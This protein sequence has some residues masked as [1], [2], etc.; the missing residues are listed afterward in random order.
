LENKEGELL[1]NDNTCAVQNRES[2][3]E[4]AQID[5]FRDMHIH[6]LL[7]KSV[8]LSNMSANIPYSINFIR[9]FDF[10]RQHGFVSRISVF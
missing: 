7:W 3:H 9:G 8:F 1:V 5:L 4:W 10:V 2:G 6:I